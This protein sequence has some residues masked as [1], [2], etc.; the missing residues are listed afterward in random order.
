GIFRF[1]DV[2][3]LLDMQSGSGTLD[4]YGTVE[5]SSAMYN[6]IGITLNNYNTFVEATGVGS[7]WMGP[8]YNKPGGALNVTGP[9]FQFGGGG[10]SEGSI[11][12]G[13]SSTFY[14]FSRF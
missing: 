4:N 7:V 13:P 6:G 8:F 2:E 3:S 1:S 10:S 9:E 11:S 14:F 12:V 5:T